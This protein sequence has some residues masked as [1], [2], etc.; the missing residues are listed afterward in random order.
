MAAFIAFIHLWFFLAMTIDDPR[1][2]PVK[3]L[4]LWFGATM[5]NPFIWMCK[6]IADAHMVTVGNALTVV[7]V[8]YSAVYVLFTWFMFIL[9][10]KDVVWFFKD[11]ISNDNV[12]EGEGGVQGSEPL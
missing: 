8:A 10:F 2:K 6:L 9:F 5:I 4:L 1:W 12:V 7:F 3:I 11:V